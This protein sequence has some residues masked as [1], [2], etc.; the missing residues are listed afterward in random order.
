[1]FS[2][3]GRHLLTW[4][5]DR[6]VR[7]VDL[8]GRPV[9]PVR[10]HSEQVTTAA[11]RPDGRGYVTA[12]RAGLIQL[13]DTTAPGAVYK[14]SNPDTV[15]AV[16]FTADGRTL[17]FSCFDGA[18]RFLDAETG[19]AVGPPL[20]PGGVI[21]SVAISPDGKN[22]LIGTDSG[23]HLVDLA[24]RR[25]L[26]EWTGVGANKYGWFYPAGDK[27]LLVVGGFAHHW[28]LA[29]EG[30]PALPRFHPEGGIDRIA[31]SPDGRYVLI[32]GGPDRSARVW[33]VATGKP[34]GP[35]PGWGGGARPVA[36]SPDGRW[37]TVGDVYGRITIWAPPAP[38]E[39]ETGRI[40]LWVQ[41]L[42]GLEIDDQGVIR[43]LAPDAL[44]ERRRQFDGQGG[45]PPRLE[46][47]DLR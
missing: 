3:D 26:R 11:F 37:L 32:S 23:V 38:I 5:E 47:T 7:L 21:W 24:T 43:S 17:L 16:D 14:V 22:L 40:K 33:D 28:A 31:I 13:W 4:A 19:R 45:P 39:G 15:S 1:M 44:A 30:D 36:F 46:K 9:G 35:P 2:P 41:T 8:S 18:V 12:D 34:L 6:T 27:A 42:T 25:S 20:R 10:P 29:G